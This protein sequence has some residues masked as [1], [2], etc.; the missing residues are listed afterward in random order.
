MLGSELILLRGLSSAERL[1]A[2]ITGG[3]GARLFLGPSTKAAEAR[4]EEPE[5]GRAMLSGRGRLTSTGEAGALAVTAFKEKQTANQDADKDF[6]TTKKSAVVNQWQSKVNKTALRPGSLLIRSMSQ[7][8]LLLF[9][10][11]SKL[12]EEAFVFLFLLSFIF[13]RH[14][15]S[16]ETHEKHSV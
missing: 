7:H 14:D 5:L 9:L 16:W 10:A 6:Q 12:A 15:V 2:T 1:W 8:Y 3:R 11:F 13:S 4:A